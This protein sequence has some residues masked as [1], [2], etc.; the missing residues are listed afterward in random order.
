MIVR[1]EEK[2]IAR[3]LDTV[4]DIVDEIIIVDTGSKDKT[5]KIVSNYTNQIYDFE[6]IDDFSA[7][8]NFS[9]SKATKDYILWLDAD[10]VILPEDREKLKKLKSELDG[11]VDVYFMKYNYNFDDKGN[12]ILIQKRERMVKREKNFKWVSPIHEVIMPSGNIKEVD[13]TINHKKLEIKDINRNL[14]IFEKMIK[15]GIELDDRQEFSYAQEFYFL[16]RIPEAII[17]HEKFIK[18]YLEQYKEEE[19]LLY[20]AIL[21]L[22]ECYKREGNIDKELESLMIILKNQKPKSECLY[23][24]GDIFLRKK[25]Y[26]TALYWLELSL[27]NKEFEENIDYSGFL[28]YIDIGV[29]YWWLGD[30]KKFEEY[31]EK[32]GSIKPTDEAYLKNKE[33][34][35]K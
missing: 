10:D 8:R 24:I 17:A 23:R 25:Q 4:K 31:N 9:F 7:A 11:T 26:E 22:S 27:E 20:P 12:P 30:M 1:D 33:F 29:C 3:C 6:W 21:R 2:V 15:K 18:K 35:I 32:A 19:Y 16:N 28:P 13:I 14:N 5:K 34:Y